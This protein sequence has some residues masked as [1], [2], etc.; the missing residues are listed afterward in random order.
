MRTRGEAY[1]VEFHT[2]TKQILMSAEKKS[3]NFSFERQKQTN[4]DEYGGK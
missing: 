4:E 3:G 2:M 1:I